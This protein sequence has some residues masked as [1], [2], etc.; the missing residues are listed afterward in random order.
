MKKLL[1]FSFF[2]F[3][4]S[5][6]FSQYMIYGTTEGGGIYYKS[7]GNP[8]YYGTIFSYNPMTHKQAVVF[9]FNDTDGYSPRTTLLYASDSL[10]YGTTYF[11]GAHNMGTVFSFNPI[12]HKET[13]VI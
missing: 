13:W 1:F 6:S 5:F 3:H 7:N 2:I 12:T 4:F 10:L 9:S 11:G 8:N